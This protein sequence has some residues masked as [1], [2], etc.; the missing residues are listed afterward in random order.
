MTAGQRLLEYYQYQTPPSAVR[1]KFLIATRNRGKT[2]FRLLQGVGKGNRR[3][4]LALQY[5][6]A[7]GFRP[8]EDRGD[9][10]SGQRLRETAT[11]IARL[12][13]QPCGERPLQRH[14]CPDS[15]MELFRA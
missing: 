9:S 13:A 7:E 15:A 4:S 11:E 14:S 2:V 1:Y 10:I 8:C 3:R 12:Q 6:A 5:I